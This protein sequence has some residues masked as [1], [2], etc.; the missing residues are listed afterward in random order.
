MAISRYIQK[1]VE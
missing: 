1:A